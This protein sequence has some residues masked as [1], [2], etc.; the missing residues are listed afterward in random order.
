MMALAVDL[1]QLSLEGLAHVPHDRLAA[2]QHLLIGALQERRDAYRHVSKTSVAYGMQSAQLRDIQACNPERQGRWSFSSQQATLHRL[3]KAFAAF[4]CRVKAG[5]I[6]GYS[7]SRGLNRFGTVES[8]RSVTDTAGA[9]PSHDPTAR[10]RLQGVRHVA[11]NQRRPVV[12]RG[13]TVSVWSGIDRGIAN[14]LSNSGSGFVPN[15]RYAH[16]AATCPPGSPRSSG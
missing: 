16:K 2:R 14:Y 9:P 3:D 4:F 11:V 12:G 8:R 7:R 1:T 13:K 6:P 15:P 5:E 10:V